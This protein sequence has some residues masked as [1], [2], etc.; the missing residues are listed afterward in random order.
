[1][2]K[3]A[4]SIL[5][6]LAVVGL[7][8]VQIDLASSFGFRRFNPGGF[9]NNPSPSPSPSLSPAPS[10]G[11]AQDPG[12]R[13]GAPGA[14]TPLPGLSAGQL[15]FFTSGQTAFNEA[16]DVGDGLGPRMNL[17][18]CGGCHAQPGLGGSSP[19]VNPQAAFASQDGG[20]DRLP[21]FITRNGPVREARFVKNADGS[22]D[23]GV[24]AIFTI[25]GRTG[26]VGC[27]LA[28]PN[29]A[30]QQANN[31]VI[32]RIPTP[33]FGGGLI[34]QIPDAAIAANQVANATQKTSLGIRGRANFQLNGR[35]IS[36]Q[37]NNNGNDGTIARFGWK[38]QNKSLQMFSGEAYN[39]EMGIT[40]DLFN[41]EREEEASCQFASTPNDTQNMDAATSP[42]GTSD[43]VK[44]AIFMRLL[45]PPAPSTNTPGGATSIANGRR[46]FTS[47][48]CALCH[49]PSFTTGRSSIAAL[50][51]RPVNLFSDLLIHDMGPGL[52]DGVSQ[53]QA[54]PTEFR[55]APLWG[56]GQRI[57]F[58]HDGRTTDLV[59]AIQQHRSGSTT[60]NNASE[61]NGVVDT[62]NNLGEGQKQDLLNFLRSL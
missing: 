55:T 24:H 19:A 6:V 28:Q 16:E 13:G 45:A 56:L 15:A 60:T 14:G 42:D 43:M 27:T 26:A 51:M 9:Q 58:L 52:A 62:F 54:G 37:T 30:A 25:T 41:T 20:T 5:F 8:M 39:V 49:T 4:S 44:F 33:T 38:A 59:Q 11:Q 61:A 40:N 48:G 53:G 46:V 34:E 18:S 21:S 57:Y 23:G 2:R 31:N 10:G 7:F 17:D 35:T 29:F 3:A 47:V 1:M 12:V 32:F 50:S 36:G 22:P